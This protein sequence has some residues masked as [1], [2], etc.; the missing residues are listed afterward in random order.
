MIAG[1]V[2]THL[3]ATVRLAIH[4][5]SGQTKEGNWQEVESEVGGEDKVAGR[6]ENLTRERLRIGL[7]S[8]TKPNHS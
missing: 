7:S 5:A 4:D 3:E 8:R 1:V 2:N 6:G